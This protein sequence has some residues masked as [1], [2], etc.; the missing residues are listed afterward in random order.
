MT[1]TV[2][3]SCSPTTH[4]LLPP[5][6]ASWTGGESADWVQAFLRNELKTLLPHALQASQGSPRG[7]QQGAEASEHSQES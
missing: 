1:L 4:S 3:K 6:P 7:L 5:N 2:I